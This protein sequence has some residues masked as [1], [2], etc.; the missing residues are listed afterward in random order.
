M[1]N[2]CHPG[3]D[4]HCSEKTEET[5]HK[6]FYQ[7]YSYQYEEVSGEVV[8]GKV[9]LHFCNSVTRINIAASLNEQEELV[10]Q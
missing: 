6:L 3:E 9:I 4:C 2:H 7:K 10:I 5:I 8:D 1:S